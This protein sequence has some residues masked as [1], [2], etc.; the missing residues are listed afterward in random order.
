MLMNTC[1]LYSIHACELWLDGAL[2]S[3]ST[4]K[5]IRLHNGVAFERVIV[6]VIMVQ[7]SVRLGT[8]K[9]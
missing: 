4:N 3:A 5:P 9:R 1:T 7:K 6:G 8:L 2:V